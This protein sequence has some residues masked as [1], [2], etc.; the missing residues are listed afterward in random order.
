MHTRDVFVR[1]LQ[2][3]LIINTKEATAT[4]LCTFPPRHSSQWRIQ[5]R[6]LN[7]HTSALARNMR[8][9]AP[10]ATVSQ[11]KGLYDIKGVLDYGRGDKNLP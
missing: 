10:P 11:E 4:Y 8:L 2:K 5:A 9:T 7:S 6:R 1:A 3:L